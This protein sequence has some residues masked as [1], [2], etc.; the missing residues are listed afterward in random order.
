MGFLNSVLKTLIAVGPAA[1]FVI[2]ILDS[3]GVPLVGGVDALLILTAV[4]TPQLA[5]LTAA[6]AV[7]GSL[8]GNLALFRA[9]FYG[10][11]K[12]RAGSG[13][14]WKTSQVPAL[15]P[16]LRITHRL[17][18]GGDTLRPAPAQG[19]RDFRRRDAYTATPLSLRSFCWR[20]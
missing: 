14:G 1:V 7:L 18:P 20:A 11:R 2:A 8:T 4:K 6:L 12:V 19:V 15:V 10:G 9:A 5:Y 3:I 17:Y 16:A 13:S